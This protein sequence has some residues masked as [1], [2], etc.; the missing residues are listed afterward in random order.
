LISQEKQEEVVSITI[1]G[2]EITK[3]IVNDMM[4]PNN[5]STEK[6]AQT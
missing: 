6:I 4:K 5:S 1:S 3:L 2:N